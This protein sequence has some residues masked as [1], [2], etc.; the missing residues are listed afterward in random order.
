MNGESIN[1]KTINNI[2]YIAKIYP[3]AKSIIILIKLY[4][5][6]LITTSILL[7]LYVSC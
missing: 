5:M 2:L 7:I 1:V 3:F 6:T 4:Y